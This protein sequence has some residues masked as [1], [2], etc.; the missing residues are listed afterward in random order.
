VRR[1]LVPIDEAKLEE[2]ITTSVKNATSNAGNYEALDPVQL[3]AGYLSG[4]A[5]C[6]KITDGCEA[7][8]FSVTPRQV[9]DV[10]ERMSHCLERIVHG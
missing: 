3:A 9:F 7:N 10:I 5:A 2:L 8:G 1:K 6:S 4:F